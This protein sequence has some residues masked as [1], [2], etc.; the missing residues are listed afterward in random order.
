MGRKQTEETK[1]KI[2]E[3]LTKL[4]H[5]RIC[6]KCKKE[7]ETKIKR[8]IYCSKKCANPGWKNVHDNISSKQWSTINK[9]AYKEGKNYVAGGTSKWIIYKD[10]KVQGTYELRTCKILDLWKEQGK[11][12]DWEY[13]NDRI[14]YIGEDEKPHSYLIDFKIYGNKNFEYIEVKGY[15]KPND[16]LKWEAVR[17]A[18]HKLEIWFE[19][20]ITKYEKT[21]Q[22][23]N[24]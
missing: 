12:K 18:G 17:N 7:F 20:N 6:S 21:L 24:K 15:K 5:K 1:R 9:K 19:K 4:P 3:A 22:T 16:T 10:I 14:E 11:I 13:T 8:R 23:L 2:R